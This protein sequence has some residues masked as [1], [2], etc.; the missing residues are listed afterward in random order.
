MKRGTG[1]DDKKIRSQKPMSNK[2]KHKEIK[3]KEMSAKGLIAV[4]LK[5]CVTMAAHMA[6]VVEWLA[7]V[8]AATYHDT[9]VAGNAK[10]NESRSYE[11]MIITMM[12]GKGK[13]LKFMR[14]EIW[15]RS[16]SR[17]FTWSTMVDDSRPWSTMG[18]HGRRWSTMVDYEMK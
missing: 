15:G 13:V 1:K 11:S 10:D 16:P 2:E 12:R 18:D 8:A 6:G 17:V 3:E 14:S 4:G 7:N 5:M 9:E